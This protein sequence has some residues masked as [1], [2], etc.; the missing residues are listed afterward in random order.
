MTRWENM[1]REKL[2]GFLAAGFLASCGSDNKEAPTPSLTGWT[3]GPIINGQNY[4]KGSDIDPMPTSTGY[5]FPLGPDTHVHYVTRPVY[6]LAGAHAITLTYRLDL[7]EGAA[8]VPSSNPIV[9]VPALITL[10]FQ[11][12][13]DD[14][15]GA[16][17]FE[18]YRWWATFATQTLQPGEHTITASMDGNW[19]AVMTSDRTKNPQ[20]FQDAI[21]HA[22]KVGFTLGGGTG[23]GHGVFATQ[24]A[25]FTILKFEVE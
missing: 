8:V 21:A 2:F 7:P 15:S 5:V 1:M 9:G 16:G 19:S 13:G 3:I 20:A 22:D 24:P 11:R 18:T 23:Y 14:W 10:Y 6:T 4:S 17:P 12:A 25:S